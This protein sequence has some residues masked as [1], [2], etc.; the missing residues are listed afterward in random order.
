[1]VTIMENIPFETLKFQALTDVTTASATF[2]QPFHD[3]SVT[4]STN[5]CHSF[6]VSR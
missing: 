5:P 4:I 1:M 3:T 2:I 6:R